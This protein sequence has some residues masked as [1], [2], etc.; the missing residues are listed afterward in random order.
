M[1]DRVENLVNMI[2]AYTL[3]GGHHLNVNVF[4]S[5]SLL[6]ALVLP[7]LYLQLTVRDSGYVVIF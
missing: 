5:D 6:D 1:S 7:E 4:F 2:D 3:S